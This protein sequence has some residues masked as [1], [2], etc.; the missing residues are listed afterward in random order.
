MKII[1]ASQ[2]PRRRELLSFMGVPFEVIVRGVDEDFPSQLDPIGA[3]RHI[4]E[5]KAMVFRTEVTDE[6]VISADTIVTVDGQILGKPKNRNEAVDMLTRLSGT[7]HDVIT[8][9][10][11]L[12]Q[13]VLHTFHEVTGVY[14]R[15]LIEDEIDY[16]IDRY[17]PFDKAGAY[18]IQEWIGMVAVEQIIGSYTNVVGLPTQQLYHVLRSS[19]PEV[20]ATDDH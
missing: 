14:F 4:A 6:L 9:V 19:F 2:S 1:L 10:S 3:V 12:H 5:K 16:Y 17:R 7:K 15:R 20:F 18:G 8:A 11:L 13:G